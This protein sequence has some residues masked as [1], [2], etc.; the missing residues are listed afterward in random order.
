RVDPYGEVLESAA[1]VYG[2]KTADPALPADVRAEQARTWITYRNNEMTND[3]VGPA[4]H[5]LRRPSQ[6]SEYEIRGLPRSGP[7]YRVTDFVGPAFDVLADSV[8]IP[9]HQKTVD[10]PPGTVSRRLL[11]RKQTLFYDDDAAAALPLHTVGF[12]ALVFESYQLA[13]T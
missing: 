2:R 9:S 8:E 5:R 3:S 11:H 10:P 4:H 12:R 13:Y 7:P 6:V 1:V